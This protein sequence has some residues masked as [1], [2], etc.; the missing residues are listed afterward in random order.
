MEEAEILAAELA[1]E[2]ADRQTKIDVL[3]KAE[4]LC[5]EE[6]E[7]DEILKEEDLKRKEMFEDTEVS[8]S[9]LVNSSHLISSRLISCHHR[10]FHAPIPQF[11]YFDLH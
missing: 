7:E 9:W 4:Q 10:S 2:E 1:G 3:K 5:D 11:V 6:R 8:T